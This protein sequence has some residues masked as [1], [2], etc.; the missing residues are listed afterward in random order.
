MHQIAIAN[1]SL[2][3]IAQAIRDIPIDRFFGTA[4]Q[5]RSASNEQVSATI[6]TGEAE[7]VETPA[8]PPARRPLRRLC[9]DEETEQLM[10]ERLIVARNLNGLDQQKAAEKLGY[11]NS[12][13]LSKVE[14]GDAPFPKSLLRRA[15]YA[16]GVS[17]DWLLGLS[18]EPERDSHL[19]SEMAVMRAVRAAVVAN[20]SIV[21]RQML[22]LAAEQMPLSNHLRSVLIATHQALATFDRCCRN[23]AYFEE[24]VRGGATLARAMDDLQ[25]VVIGVE[26]AMARREAVALARIQQPVLEPGEG[27]DDCGEA[28]SDWGSYRVKGVAIADTHAAD[29]SR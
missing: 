8:A 25:E 29:R 15:A 28:L 27:V 7:P 18:N 13:Q 17:S 23:D 20:T 19:A 10:R 21:T 16:Y 6:E 26:K 4:A 2:R 11:K 3:P 9:E 14:S 24:E 1:C 12:S 5:S 22:D